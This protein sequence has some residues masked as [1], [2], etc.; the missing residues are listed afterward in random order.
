MELD[1]AWSGGQP[2]SVTLRPSA[3]GTYSLR[4][5]AESHIVS[6]QSGD[7]KMAVPS[8]EPLRLNV[9]AGQIYHMTLSH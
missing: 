2:V 6:L 3:D 1:L 5:P 4:Y 9:R 8:G 7:R